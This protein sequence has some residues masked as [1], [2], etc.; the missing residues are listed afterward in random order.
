MIDTKRA[1]LFE[2]QKIYLIKYTIRFIHVVTC[3]NP[4]EYTNYLF[5][6][7]K[8]G[9]VSL[10]PSPCAPSGEKRSGEQSQIF[11]G[12]FPKSNKDQ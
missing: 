9:G 1:C 4:L 8:G 2:C 5:S 11:L 3:M 10:V 7:Q 6:P 12:L